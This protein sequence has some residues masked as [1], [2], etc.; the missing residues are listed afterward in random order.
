V[1]APRRTTGVAGTAIPRR[2]NTARLRRSIKIAGGRRPVNAPASG[3]LPWLALA[4]TSLGPDVRW[5]VLRALLLDFNGVLVD[6]EPLH[7]E[8]LLRVLAEEGAAAGDPRELVGRDDRSCF[9]NALG[10]AG[11]PAGAERIARLVAR[12]A[13]YY[14]QAVRAAGYPFFPA[15][16]ALV[17]EAAAARLMLG[18][19]SGAL[20]DEVEGA[21]QQAGVRHLFKVVVAAEDVAEGKPSPEGYRLAVA[22]LNALPPLPERLLH[23]HE[24]LAIED[25]PPGL[26]AA[27][28]AGLVTLG[29]AHSFPPGELHADRVAVGLGGLSLLA[30]Q[31]LYAEASR[32]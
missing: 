14:Q 8:L 16:L 29:V 24:V 27:R 31:D 11:Q 1:L 32:A 20:L 12:K 22:R 18:V 5:G 3:A 9:A 2:G 30:L 10:A 28:D 7:R 15:S 23:P 4:A 6:D 21:L 17:R 13:S 26:A 25:S 19:V